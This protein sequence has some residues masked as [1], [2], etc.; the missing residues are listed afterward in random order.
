MRGAGSPQLIVD[1]EHAYSL[2]VGTLR[3]SLP[4]SNYV[5]HVNGLLYAY[6]STNVL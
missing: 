5:A 2:L 4:P 3:G 6:Y 1:G